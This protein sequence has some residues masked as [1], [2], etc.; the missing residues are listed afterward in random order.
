ME[1]HETC[2]IICPLWN[3]FVPKKGF[4]I[5][6]GL[7]CQGLSVGEIDEFDRKACDSFVSCQLQIRLKDYKSES[8]FIV[9]ADRMAGRFMNT[10]LARLRLYT[11]ANIINGAWNVFLTE[12]KLGAIVPG[13]KMSIH[14][15]SGKECYL[16]NKEGQKY[17]D[18][19]PSFNE[20]DEL[21][22]SIA[23][24]RFNSSFSRESMADQLIDLMVLMES[25]FNDSSGDTTY[26][27]VTRSSFLISNKL[28]KESDKL[29]YRR[30]VYEWVQRAYSIRSNILHGV[31]QPNDEELFEVL[32]KLQDIVLN[33]L[34]DSFKLKREGKV[35]LFKKNKGA[36]IDYYLMHSL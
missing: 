9:E 25:L 21:Y 6:D 23:I 20:I 33:V 8:D 30:Y 35:N 31:I 22:T 4:K 3:I 34:V 27:I 14:K 19:L 11:K 1:K 13:E 26:K 10:L 5:E 24:S 29:S 2:F 36:E 32:F 7:L 12:G 17:L 18:L 15:I 28:N 16:D